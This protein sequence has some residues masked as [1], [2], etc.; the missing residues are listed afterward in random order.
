[1]DGRPREE[2]QFQ[3]L[4]NSTLDW[5][6]GRE[7]RPAGCMLKS[8]IGLQFPPRTTLDLPRLSLPSYLGLC[9]F[10]VWVS[11]SALTTPE[12]FYHLQQFGI[13]ELIREY[14]GMFL[15]WNIDYQGSLLLSLIF[16]LVARNR[17]MGIC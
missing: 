13:G 1:M 10:P 9:C 7:K 2:T 14:P 17:G 8:C 6:E 4:R 5:A 15:E 3:L 16:T 12:S 11:R